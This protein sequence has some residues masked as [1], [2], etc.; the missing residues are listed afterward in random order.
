MKSRNGTTGRGLESVA[1][2]KAQGL[3]A[4]LFPEL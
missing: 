2:L 1:H 4:R 3:L